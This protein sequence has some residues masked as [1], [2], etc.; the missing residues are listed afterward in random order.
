MKR[1]YL[2][3]FALQ[4][5]LLAQAPSTLLRGELNGYN[6]NDRLFVE[7]YE[8]GRRT[9]VDRVPVLGGGRFEVG[10]VQAGGHY[11]VRIVRTNGDKLQS[12]DVAVNS[13]SFPIDIRIPGKASSEFKK[14]E[15]AWIAGR[16]EES[17]ERL[18]K[19]LKIDPG[20]MDA[21]NN[22]GTKL[23]ANGYTARAMEEFRKSIE[24][25]PAAAPAHLNLAICLLA[26]PKDRDTAHEA[27]MHARKALQVDPSALSARFALGIA[28]S[29]LNSVEALPY[30][31]ESAERYPRAIVAAPNML[32]RLGRRQEAREWRA[33]MVPDH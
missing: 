5:Y 18:E 11:E 31:R 29:W 1:S 26:D 16:K 19:A 23:L 12:E 30:L 32:A 15:M 2:F 3:G 10:G 13:T 24:L 7:V 4:V 8:Q 22:L 14:A 25:D 17:I 33:R 9:M 21:H 6:P 28:L 20:Y 27:E